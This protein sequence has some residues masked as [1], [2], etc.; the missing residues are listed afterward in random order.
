MKTNAGARRALNLLALA[1]MATA[2]ACA[3]GAPTAPLAAGSVRTLTSVPCQVSM[4][5]RK[6]TC[7][8]LG[9]DG[10]NADIFSSQGSA[11]KLTSSNVS[12]NSGTQI[13]QFDVT[14]QNLMN[15]AI[16]TP[17]GTT[18]AARGIR[19]FFEAEPTTTAGTGSVT[20]ANRDG[21]EFFTAPNQPYFTYNTVL[22]KNAVSGAKTWR[23]NVPSTVTNF[24]FKVYIETDVQPLLVINEVLTRPG[25]GIADNNGEWFEIYNAGSRAVNLQDYL[26]ADSSNLGRRPYHKINASLVV[27][28]GGY[29]VLGRSTNTTL[30]GGVSVDYAYGAALSLVSSSD[31]I[32]ISRVAGSDTLTIDRISYA[33]AAISAIMG[34]SRELKNPALDNSNMDGSNWANGLVSF[35]L[36]GLGSPKLVNASLVP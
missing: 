15:E 9:L 31:A 25:G 22:A 36:G 34:V 5:D 27:P 28:A 8:G 18:P 3:D 16:G 10:V 12:Y 21:I 33:N 7:G 1:G 35:G 30:N 29:V 26:I 17:D 32:K 6:V 23:L 13:F 4:A 20:V 2:V 19:V 11:V 14:V 24:S